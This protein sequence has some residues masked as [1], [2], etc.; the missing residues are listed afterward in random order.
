MA[1]PAVTKNPLGIT[2]FWQKASAEPPI[3]W[4]KWIQQLFLGM[5]TKDGI[6]LSK[7]LQ[8]PLRF[9]DT[10]NQGTNSQ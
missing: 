10:K 5:I 2:P 3:E 4:D 1:Q 8:D 6:D 9:D 7:L